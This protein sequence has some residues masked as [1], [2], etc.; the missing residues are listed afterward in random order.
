MKT[1]SL[2]RV[3][4]YYDLPLI[5]EGEDEDGQRYL[6]DSLTTTLEGGEVFLA[7]AVTDSQIVKLNRGDL[8]LRS[9]LLSAGEDGWYQSVPQRNFRKP[10]TLERQEGPI[11]ACPNLPQEGYMLDG[12][13]DD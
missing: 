9:A 10:F 7:V 6:C 4:E 11:S 13:W 2:T 8:C 5:F 3:L 1:I 12:A